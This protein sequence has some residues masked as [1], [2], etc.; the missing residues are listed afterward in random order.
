MSNVLTTF[1]FLPITLQILKTFKITLNNVRMSNFITF[2]KPVS[3]LPYISAF[4]SGDKASQADANRRHVIAFASI[5]VDLRQFASHL[6][7]LG[8]VY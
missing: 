6:K 8:N 1:E 2:K 7:I 3:F 4:H 5:C